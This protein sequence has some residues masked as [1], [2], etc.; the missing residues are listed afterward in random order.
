MDMESLPH[1]GQSDKS[2]SEGLCY[3][4]VVKPAKKIVDVQLHSRFT[5]PFR[6]DNNRHA[7][8][9]DPVDELPADRVDRS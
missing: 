7:K 9:L 2:G 1:G 4:V 3:L 8:S 6:D 5:N